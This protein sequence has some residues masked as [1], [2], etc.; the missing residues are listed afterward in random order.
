VVGDIQPGPD[1]HVQDG[2]VD[3]D[4]DAVAGPRLQR[5]VERRYEEG[6]LAEV[7][8]GLRLFAE[9]RDRVR[10]PAKLEPQAVGGHRRAVEGQ[11]NGVHSREPEAPV[12]GDLELEGET[13]RVSL[14]ASSVDQAVMRC[15]GV[16]LGGF[17]WDGCRTGVNP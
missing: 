4:A 2:H 17:W 1:L 6:V 12:P 15:H 9:L 16:L 14:E 13:V 8:E 11:G 10:P 7:P 3:R 5:R